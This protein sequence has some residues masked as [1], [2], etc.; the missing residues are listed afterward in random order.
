MAGDAGRTFVR[1]ARVPLERAASE[2]HAGRIAEALGELARGSLL[3][4]LRRGLQEV[5]QRTGVP[6]VDVKRLLPGPEIDELLG[7]VSASQAAAAKAWKHETAPQVVDLAPE[8]DELPDDQG[9]IGSVLSGVAAK[10]V[11]D[12]HL[13]APLDDLAIHLTRWEDL[14]HRCGKVLASDPTLRRASARKIIR[15]LSV[16]LPI[17]AVIAVAA[18]LAVAGG[19]RRDRIRAALTNLD[20]CAPLKEAD[21]ERISVEERQQ[22]DLRQ[23]Q[24]AARRARVA[25]EARCD[26]LATAVEQRTIGAEEAATA[27]TSQPVLDRIARGSLEVG[28]LGDTPDL[29]CG[30]TPAGERLWDAFGRAAST[31][32]E[33]WAKADHV[34]ER[35]SQL[36]A[37]HPLSDRAAAAL[38]DHAEAVAKRGILS[39]KAAMI[40]QAKKL[41]DLE[42]SLHLELR[43]YCDGIAAVLAQS[44][45]PRL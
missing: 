33:A 23:S 44:R 38:G 22:Y 16:A 43:Q 13:S 14:L 30:D 29:P 36:L 27:G 4:G 7:E 34:G 31:S 32:V 24:C 45:S 1:Q 11:R 21:L 28:D 17:A 41:C 37:S 26:A 40:E 9:A 6:F 15:A 5:S 20:A 35:L 39:G 12:K 19:G 42:K 2:L 25:Y 8:T 3:A 10:V 18:G